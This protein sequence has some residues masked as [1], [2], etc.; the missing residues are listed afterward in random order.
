MSLNRCTLQR[1]LILPS[2]KFAELPRAGDPIQKRALAGDDLHAPFE[3]DWCTTDRAAVTF[4]SASC[5]TDYLEE[6]ERLQDWCDAFQAKAGSKKSASR[7][8]RLGRNMGRL[9]TL[10]GLAAA[11]STGSQSLSVRQRLTL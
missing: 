6:I 4:P 3:R 7:W 9:A 5:W 8:A 2:S 10:G 1:G 11:P